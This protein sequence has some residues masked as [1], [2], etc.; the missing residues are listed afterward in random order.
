MER[1]VHQENR[2]TLI[3]NN[4]SRCHSEAIQYGEWEIKV[5]DQSYSLGT[6]NWVVSINQEN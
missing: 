6:Y 4:V 3:A 1:L 2:N 5:R